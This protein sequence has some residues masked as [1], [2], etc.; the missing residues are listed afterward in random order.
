VRTVDEIVVRA[1]L[2]ACFQAGADVERWPA[3]LPHY[4]WVR[5]QRRDGFG[6]GRVEMAARRPFGP[7]SYPVW[8]VSEMTVDADRPAVRY[9]HVAGVTTGMDVE[10]TFADL[11]DGSTGITIVHEW[12]DGPHWPVP[13][14][15]RRAVADRVIGPVFIHHVAARTLRGIRRHLEGS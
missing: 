10:W 11:G 5:F 2:D 9:R 15:L 6:Q 1:P 4:R 3:R 12:D 13:S 14:P 7:L 8:W